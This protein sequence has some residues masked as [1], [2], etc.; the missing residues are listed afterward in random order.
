MICHKHKCIFI[1][2]LKCAGSSI[3]SYLTQYA[4]VPYDNPGEGPLV[5]RE[6]TM[7][8][9]I[10]LY[11]NYFTFTFVRNPFDRFV[12]FYHHS[13]RERGINSPSSTAH[14]TMR[15]HAELVA[16]IRADN[17]PLNEKHDIYKLPQW[18]LKWYVRHSKPQVDFLLDENPATYFGVPRFNDAP[19]SF[20]GRVENLEQDF[21]KL[22]TI[23]GIPRHPLELKMVSTARL[24]Q[25]IK[26]R[27]HYSHYYDKSIRRLV[28][29]LYA[30]DLK[31]LDYEFEEEG[32]TQTLKPLYDMQKAQTIPNATVDIRRPQ[33]V[34]IYILRVLIRVRLKILR[35]RETFMSFRKNLYRI[36]T[37]SIAKA[38]TTNSAV[39][40]VYS[41]L[42]MPVKRRLFD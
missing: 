40:C 26:Q 22:C 23:L 5:R 11:P 37:Q 20:I 28:E 8:H 33:W 16:K 2:I 4:G 7:A 15:E 17:S 34:K 18:L 6:K 42:L 32:E 3:R 31:L 19:C 10:N 30:Q 38:A 12:S 29:E 39:N 24:K 25:G 13:L 27:K 36:I 35:I 1:H 41:K 14:Y 9:L 21:R